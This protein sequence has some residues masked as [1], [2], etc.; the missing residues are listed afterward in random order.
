MQEKTPIGADVEK[1]ATQVVDAGFHVFQG[2]GPGLPESTYEK[3]LVYELIKRGLSVKTQVNTPLCYDG[4]QL[5]VIYQIQ[6]IV[7]D[8]IIVSVKSVDETLPVHRSEV[9]TWLRVSNIRLGFL[10]NF[11]VC[12]FKE[13][14]RRVIY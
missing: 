7:N 10:M 3:I 12:K 4:E 1:I 9:L 2:L 6:I 5:D 8:C 13:G 14:I 11:N